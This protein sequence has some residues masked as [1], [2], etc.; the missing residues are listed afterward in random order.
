[1]IK[2]SQETYRLN[3]WVQI[4]LWK[5][6]LEYAAQATIKIAEIIIK[7]CAI[8]FAFVWEKQPCK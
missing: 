7:D 3:Y 5:K 6:K 2:Q 4:V 8:N 1:M